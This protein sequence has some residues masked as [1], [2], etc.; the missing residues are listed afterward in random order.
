M[1]TEITVRLIRC[2]FTWP[3]F[4]GHFSSSAAHR[5]IILLMSFLGVD[6]F[7]PEIAC[8]D[9]ALE[10]LTELPLFGILEWLSSLGAF[11]REAATGFD[12]PT[13]SQPRLFI[14]SAG[15]TPTHGHRLMALC[16]IIICYCYKSPTQISSK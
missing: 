4:V 12:A 14:V 6:I 5:F 10:A 16:L 1:H 2:L 11:R 8:T 3:D 9:C 13:E 15:E 7:F